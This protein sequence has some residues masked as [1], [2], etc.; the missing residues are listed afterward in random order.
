MIICD[1][2]CSFS[3]VLVVSLYMLYAFFLTGCLHT[4]CY[5]I[6]CLY[7]CRLFSKY[8]CWIGIL[9]TEM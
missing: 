6:V 2:L 1:I 9:D 5:F 4:A 3:V 7:F 8:F